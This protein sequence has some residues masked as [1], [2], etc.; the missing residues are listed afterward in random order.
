MVGV[1]RPVFVALL[2]FDGKRL[3]V[4]GLGGGEVALVFG[5][6]AQLVVG[7][8][9]PVFVA[10]LLADAE[11]L[12]VRGLGGGKVALHL[13]NPAQLVVGS[14]RSVFVALLLTD[15][16]RLPVPGLGGFEVA[17]LFGNRA[18][19][20][21][22]GGEVFAFPAGLRPVL[23]EAGVVARG[24]GEIT[25]RLGMSAQGLEEGFDVVLHRERLSELEGGLE[26]G[27]MVMEDLAQ[28]MPWLGCRPIGEM[29]QDADEGPSPGIGLG[30]DA[31]GRQTTAQE[32]GEGRVEARR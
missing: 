7:A 9:R 27:L 19:L 31:E 29:A 23:R 6:R 22:G 1:G 11:R 30:M 17:L 10:L 2:L 4:P 16:E 3:P 21:V 8:G 24:L 32:T 25:L 15:A 13:G 5:N 28:D 12:P 20:V 26:I 14:G 18:Q